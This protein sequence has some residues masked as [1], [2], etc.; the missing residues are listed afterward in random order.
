MTRPAESDALFDRERE[1]LDRSDDGCSRDEIALL[2]GLKPEYVGKVIAMYNHSEADDLRAQAA[3][4]A[5]SQA[6]AQ[7]CLAT[8]SSFR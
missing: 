5:S 8:G 4:R 7:A 6:L 1:I 3:I 2:L